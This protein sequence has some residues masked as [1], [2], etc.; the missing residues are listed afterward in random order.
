MF[1]IGDLVTQKDFSTSFMSDFLKRNLNMGVVGIV[2]EIKIELDPTSSD[3]F[4]NMVFIRWSNGTIE[5][6]PEIYLEKV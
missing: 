1:S 5:K 4:H 2:L 3:V 6:L